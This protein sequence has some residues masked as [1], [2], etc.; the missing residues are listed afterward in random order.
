M[1]MS[2]TWLLAIAVACGLPFGETRAETNGSA[3]LTISGRISGASGQHTV[4]V[5]VWD[6]DGFLVKP[7]QVVIL[8]RGAEPRFQFVVPPGRFALSAFED[9]NENGVLDMGLFGPKEPSGFWRPFHG[10]HKPRFDEVATRFDH[11]VTD[12]DIELK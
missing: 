3:T 8:P 11:P 1:V 5:A 6:A 2:R 10:R 7:L 4:R 12:A 9:R